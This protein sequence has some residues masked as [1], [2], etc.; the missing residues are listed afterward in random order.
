MIQTEFWPLL[1]SSY[2]QQRM[3]DKERGSLLTWLLVAWTLS[4]IRYPHMT[5]SWK[6]GTMTVY[7]QSNYFDQIVQR[8][9]NTIA[10]QFYGHSHVVCPFSQCLEVVIQ[11]IFSRTNLKS[12]IQITV[13]RTLILRLALPTLRLR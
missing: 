3:P 4:L 5:L 13:I 2:K 7:L 9:N 10:A 12:R 6:G 8:Y 11:F 1:L